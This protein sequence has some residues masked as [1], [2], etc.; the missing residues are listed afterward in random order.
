MIHP[1]LEVHRAESDAIVETLSTDPLVRAVLRKSNPS[2]GYSTARGVVEEGATQA[3][4]AIVNER[5]G[6]GRSVDEYWRQHDGGMHLLAAA[7]YARM[8]QSGFA[9]TGGDALAWLDGEIRSGRLRDASLR[10]FAAGVV[11]AHHVRN[12][13]G[14]STAVLIRSS[15]GRHRRTELP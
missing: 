9:D 5:L 11:G 13:V 14:H 3:L 1:F 8:K 4:E 7:I 2:F 6:H 12:W 15:E 10:D